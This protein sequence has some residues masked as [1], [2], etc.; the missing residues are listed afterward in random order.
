[1]PQDLWNWINDRG[2]YLREPTV[3]EQYDALLRFLTGHSLKSEAALWQSFMNLKT[4]RNTFVHEGVAKVGGTPISVDVARQL[5]SGANDVIAKVREWLPV[6][7]HWP[8]F[9]HNVQVEI[10]KR[11]LREQS[12]NTAKSQEG[13]TGTEE[14]P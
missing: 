7:M 1:V 6:A 9:K 14:T 4:A 5:V 13:E 11:I 12:S 8:V 10:R 2:N 3:E